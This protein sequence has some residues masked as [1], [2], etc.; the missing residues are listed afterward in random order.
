MMDPG[1]MGADTSTPAQGQY[2][3]FG[4]QNGT[5][6]KLFGLDLPTLVPGKP[7]PPRPQAKTDFSNLQ[8][9]DLTTSLMDTVAQLQSEV[10]TL[11]FAPPV[12]PTATPCIQPAQ[13]RPASFTTTEV[14][15]SGSTSWDLYRPVFDAMVQVEWVGRRH[16]RPVAPVPP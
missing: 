4:P 2:P 6:P 9:A 13:P 5:R 12:P 8:P 7:P 10:Y 15:K 1:T 3:R 16:S 14:P 11:K